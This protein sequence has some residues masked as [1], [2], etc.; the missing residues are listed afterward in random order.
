MS[1][2]LEW[3]AERRELKLPWFCLLIVKTR[4]INLRVFL[5]TISC[6]SFFPLP[7]PDFVKTKTGLRPGTRQFAR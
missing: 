1:P 3:M 2:G 6:L 7:Q 5:F 4:R